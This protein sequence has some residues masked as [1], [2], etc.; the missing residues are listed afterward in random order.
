MLVMFIVV[1][2]CRWFDSSVGICW[3]AAENNWHLLWRSCVF[4]HKV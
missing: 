4:R 2:L 1:V 3:F